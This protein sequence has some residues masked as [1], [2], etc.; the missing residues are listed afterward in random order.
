VD[1]SGESFGKLDQLMC[2]RNVDRGLRFHFD[3]VA[4]AACAYDDVG[5]VAVA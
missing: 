3:D 1:F 5:A 2:V 4:Y